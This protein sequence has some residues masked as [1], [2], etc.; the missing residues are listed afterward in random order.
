MNENTVTV[1]FDDER[2]NLDDIVKALND[3]GYTVPGHEKVE[4]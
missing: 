4:G 2:Q 3:A 1:T